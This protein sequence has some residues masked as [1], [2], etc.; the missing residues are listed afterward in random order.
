MGK[1]DPERVIILGAVSNFAMQ[2][3]GTSAYESLMSEG[4]DEY[5]SVEAAVRN[6]HSVGAAVLRGLLEE[7]TP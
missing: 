5:S 3:K 1:A 7:R 2:W 4:G 6:V